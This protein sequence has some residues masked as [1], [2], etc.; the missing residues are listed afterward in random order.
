MSPED[1]SERVPPLQKSKIWK[2]WWVPTENGE[3]RTHL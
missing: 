3:F 2:V 1:I